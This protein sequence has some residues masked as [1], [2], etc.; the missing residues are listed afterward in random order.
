MLLATIPFLAGFAT[1]NSIDTGGAH[2]GTE[3]RGAAA[4]CYEGQY[5]RYEGQYIKVSLS[6]HIVF[7]SNLSFSPSF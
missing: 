3:S 5:A 1:P 7:S 4:C 6:Y 2:A